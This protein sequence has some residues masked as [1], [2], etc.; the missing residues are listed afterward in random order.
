MNQNLD[1]EK[2]ISENVENQ[3]NIS[4]EE[5]MNIQSEETQEA[6]MPKNSI[7]TKDEVLEKLK[8]FLAKE[9]VTLRAEVENLK[10]I[11]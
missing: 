5:N 8:D 7:L 2:N 1:P 3:K 11:I 4:A 6:S 10:Q 9:E